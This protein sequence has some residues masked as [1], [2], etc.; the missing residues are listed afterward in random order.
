MREITFLLERE[1]SLIR[2]VAE[3][4]FGFY[5]TD[6]AIE[7]I[8]ASVV[9][10][11]QHLAWRN[12]HECWSQEREFDSTELLSTGRTTISFIQVAMMRP[13]PILVPGEFWKNDGGKDVFVPGGDQGIDRK[14]LDRIKEA[15]A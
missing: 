2:V 7:R 11:T 10:P 15:C 4:L 9:P 12:Y 13:P 3:N 1:E 14:T 6:T 8:V 5:L